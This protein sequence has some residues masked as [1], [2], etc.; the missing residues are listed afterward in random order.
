[1][2]PVLVESPYAGDVERNVRYAW[3]CLRNS[4]LRGEAPLRSGLGLCMV[5]VS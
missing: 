1:M 2:R 3:A 5:D 4:L